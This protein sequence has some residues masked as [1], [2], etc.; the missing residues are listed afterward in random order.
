M[1]QNKDLLSDRSN[2]FY[3]D[4]NFHKKPWRVLRL[5]VEETAWGMEGSCEYVEQAITDYRQEVVLHP[6]SSAAG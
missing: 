3:T 5:R 4:R 1:E 6:G 2:D